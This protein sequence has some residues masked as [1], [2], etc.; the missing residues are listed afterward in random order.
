MVVVLALVVAA[1]AVLLLLVEGGGMEA[2]GDVE[3]GDALEGEVEDRIV[4]DVVAGIWEAKGANDAKEVG[5]GMEGV[6]IGVEE[7]VGSVY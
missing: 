3:K 7:D 4:L 6:N 2:M 1:K 5:V